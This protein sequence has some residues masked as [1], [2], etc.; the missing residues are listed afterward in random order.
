MRRT[1]EGWLQGAVYMLD[2]TLSASVE[3]GSFSNEELFLKI[4]KANI[5]SWV[6]KISS[7]IFKEFEGKK[8][9]I[10]I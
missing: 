6:I 2:E 5:L 10:I 1:G 9:G 4:V 3:L 8:K 7:W